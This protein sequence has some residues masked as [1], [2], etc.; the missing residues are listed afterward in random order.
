MAMGAGFPKGLRVLVIDEGL[1]SSLVEAQLRQPDLAYAV[2]T[3]S[4]ST[5]ALAYSR[6]GGAAFDVVLAES[7]LVAVDEVTGRAF[8]D[9][10]EETPVVLMSEG[11]DSGDVM[12][13]V[14]L[15]AVDFLDK[16]LSLLK[17]KNIWQHSVRKMMQR[18]NGQGGHGG[19][20]GYASPAPAPSAAQLQLHSSP[21]KWSL[22]PDCPGTPSG[23]SDRAEAFSAGSLLQSE[24]CADVSQSDVTAR[25]SADLDRSSFDRSS[26]DSDQASKRQARAPLSFKPSSF[27]PLVP[28]PPVSQWPRLGSGCVWGTPVGGPMAPPMPGAAPP[29]SAPAAGGFAWAPLP[30][31]RTASPELKPGCGSGMMASPGGA[32]PLSIPEGFLSPDAMKQSGCGPIGLR[33]KK[34]ESLLQLINTTLTSVDEATPMCC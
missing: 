25:A 5:E 11:G 23:D 19:G 4:T 18:A 2:T 33:L 26:F 27:G 30:P 13:A 15:G 9:A 22:G 16:P 24:L 32:E 34:S 29:A 1:S 17:L 21:S 31:A 7:K 12:R 14:K 28:V 3:C 20:G 10:F 6:S 8:I